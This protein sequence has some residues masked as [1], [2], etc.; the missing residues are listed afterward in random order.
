MEDKLQARPHQG[1]GAAVDAS[2]FL[3]YQSG[4]LVCQLAIEGDEMNQGPPWELFPLERALV[5]RVL[6]ARAQAFRREL[7]TAIQADHKAHSC[8]SRHLWLRLAGPGK[9]CFAQ[10]AKNG[11]KKKDEK[12]AIKSAEKSAAKGSLSTLDPPSGTRVP[13]LHR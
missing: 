12:K 13:R 2:T 9:V 4:H 10:D 3:C 1:D 11:K 8:I 6:H 7:Q 5:S